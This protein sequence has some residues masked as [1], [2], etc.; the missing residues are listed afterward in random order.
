MCGISGIIG[1]KDQKEYFLKQMVNIQ[2]HRGPDASGIYISS[3]GFAGLG[4]NRLSI[5]DLTSA[6]NQ[7][8]ADSSGQY[9]I[10]YNGEIYNYLELRNELKSYGEIFHTS[11]DT[12]V[13]LISFRRW[14]EKCLDKIVGMFSFA[15]WDNKNRTLFAARDR[16]GVKPFYYSLE[17]NETF[18]FASE[19]KAIHKAGIKRENNAE[20]WATYLAYGVYEHSVST[21]WDKIYSLPPGHYLQWK[22]SK[23]ELINWYD[24]RSKISNGYD[25]RSTQEIKEEYTSL[26]RESVSYRF[27]S[28]VPVGINLSG[29]LDS[30]L[31]LGYVNES[32]G[33][34]NSVNAFTF[35]TGDERYDELPWV[36]MM[37]EKTKHPLVVCKLNISEIPELAEE[38]YKIQD[39]PY[40]GIPT[41]A[42]SKIFYEAKKNG[43]KVLLDGQGMDE[44]WAG[45]EYYNNSRITEQ[46]LVNG[47]VQGSK[48]RS[49]F[50]ECLNEE[51]LQIAKPINFPRAGIDDIQNLQYRDTRFLKIPRALRFNDRISM[52]HSTELR[53]PF[54]DHR[55][56]EL[57]LIQ[58]EERKIKNG[59][60]KWMLRYIARELIPDNVIETPKRS[61]QTPQ[62]EWLR[63]PLSRWAQDQ[64]E[65]A[66]SSNVS[67]LNPKKVRKEWK[68][69]TNGH[70][71]NSF[72]I[73]QWI[74]LGININLGWF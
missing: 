12:E 10:S 5:I 60:H 71:D 43:I 35:I 67:W 36:K 65:T 24:L 61:L 49:V 41:I 3:D 66:L 47:P 68:N 48:N 8:M 4:H 70:G 33:R 44:Q 51:F 73:W 32:Q 20:T 27:R 69:F 45:Y 64:I 30:S 19:I 11:S 7:P 55:L 22:D 17:N 56:F 28:D 39:E 54:L 40:G 59:I 26:L 62:I 53:E 14:G 52:L 1:S 21:F 31:L 58:P 25:E 18:I 57:A 37:L 38:I 74:S 72:Y 46:S 23:L 9:W 2:N 63:E 29:G 16:F 6:G 15:I 13:L 34:D 42:Y 50:P